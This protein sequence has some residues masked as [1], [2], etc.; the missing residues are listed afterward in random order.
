MYEKS[1]PLESSSEFSDSQNY[2]NTNEHLLVWACKI[3]E[4]VTYQELFSPLFKLVK[5][6][7][8]LELTFL[9]SLKLSK[10]DKEEF[11]FFWL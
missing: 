2:E 7:E 11:L 1:P 8:R 10:K 9:D 4:S 5:N 3:H 6:E